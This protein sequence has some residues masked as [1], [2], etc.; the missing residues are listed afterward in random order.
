MRDRPSTRTGDQ[1]DDLFD[2]N[3]PSFYESADFANRVD[4]MMR[5]GLTVYIRSHLRAHVPQGHPAHLDCDDITNE[6]VY[7]CLK[8]VNTALLC[9]APTATERARLFRAF[10][11]KVANNC[12]WD[13]RDKHRRRREISVD[14]SELS[15]SIEE[16]LPSIRS[17]GDSSRADTG[18]HQAMRV[19]LLKLLAQVS[20]E[21]QRLL[22]LRLVVGFRWSEIE[23][24]F[25]GDYSENR[26]KVRLHRLV[27]RLRD[28]ASTLDQ[29]QL[30]ESAA[31]EMSR[32]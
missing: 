4:A 10:L 1:L 11:R 5:P 22:Y 19:H 8:G 29:T 25:D 31:H 16:P 17:N 2:S 26:L 3:V 20:A 12:V 27:R 21:D 28:Q 14:E 7:K 18:R 30:P 15:A 9:S 24:D 32:Q 6:V 13:V 23:R